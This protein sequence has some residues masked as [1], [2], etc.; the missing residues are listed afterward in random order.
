MYRKYLKRFGLVS[1]ARP[2][3]IKSGRNVRPM[4]VSHVR[5]RHWVTKNKVK[6]KVDRISIEWIT[7]S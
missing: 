4:C 2:K 3:Q 1:H 5:R 6:K 7:N